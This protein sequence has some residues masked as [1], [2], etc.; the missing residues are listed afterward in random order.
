MF[1]FQSEVEKMYTFIVPIVFIG[2]LIIVERMINYHME[3]HMLWVRLFLAAGGVL[4]FLALLPD[5]PA[6]FFFMKCGNIW[7]GWLMYFVQIMLVLHI[8]ALIRNKPH[9][10]NVIIAAVCSVGINAYGMYNAQ[11]LKVIRYELTTQKAENFRICLVADF[12]LSTNTSY[13]Y[14]QKIVKTINETNADLVL[15][16]GDMFTSTYHGLSHP[17]KYEALFRQI[18]STHGAYGV[19]GNHDN[20]ETLLCGFPM[21]RKAEC[22]RSQEMDDFMANSGWKVLNDEVV[23]FDDLN[24]TLIG[25]QDEKTGHG[26]EERASFESFKKDIDNDRYTIVLTHEPHEY[27]KISQSEKK[28]D[29]IMSGHTHNGQVFP[30]TVFTRFF[31][32]LAFGHKRMNDMDAIV[33]AGVG[34]YGPPIRVGCHAD[35]MVIDVKKA[36]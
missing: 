10:L 28:V 35:I 15:F 18:Q 19:Y 5:S 12:H 29:L 32:E 14:V 34:F 30:G 7:I 8:I 25:R 27:K 33:T 13:S 3:D 4:V 23:R 16:G 17:E 26:D 6:R 31:N 22:F 24:V 11:D 9:M 36:P 1:E 21:T 20:E 2:G